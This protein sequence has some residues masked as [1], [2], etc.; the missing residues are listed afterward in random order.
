M[1]GGGVCHSSVSSAQSGRG[2]AGACLTRHSELS[3]IVGAAHTD[4][5]G[6]VIVRKRTERIFFGADRKA[7]GEELCCGRLVGRRARR[8]GKMILPGAGDRNAS[9]TPVLIF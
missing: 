8:A 7:S 1:L 4:G 2:G 5:E 3:V 6:G 9:R